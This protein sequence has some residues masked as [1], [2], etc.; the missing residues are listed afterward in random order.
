M[1]NN[2]DRVIRNVYFVAECNLM[3]L[4]FFAA[5]WFRGLGFSATKHDSILFFSALVSWMLATAWTRFRRVYFG[6]SKRLFACLKT[7]LLFSLF[8]TLLAFS[9]KEAGY[10][11]LIVGYFIALFAVFVAALHFTGDLYVYAL[12]R[13]HELLRNVMALGHP[14]SLA[15]LCEQFRSHPEHG[16]AEPVIHSLDILEDHEMLA[17]LIRQHSVNE[18]ILVVPFGS[19]VDFQ[20]VFDEMENFGV[21]VSIIPDMSLSVPVPLR[22]GKMFDYPVFLLQQF[23]LDDSVNKLWK[24]LFDVFFSAGVLLVLSPIFLIIALYVKV[25]SPGPVLFQQKRTGYNQKEFGVYKFRSMRFDKQMA[26][27]LQAT[28]SDPRITPVG[29]FMR[30]T[31]IDELPQFWNVLKGDMS[32]VGPR[33]HMLAHTEEFSSRVGGY[34]WRHHVRPGITGWAQVNGWRGLTDTEEK[35][36]KRVECDLWYVENW[37]LWLDIKIVFMTLFAQTARQNAV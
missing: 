24:R 27:T 35:I 11:R 9:F 26:N 21:R 13:S 37:T 10:S 4:A 1:Y 18:L 12:H 33:P 3:L 14:D 34:L 7:L 32:V 25:T 22:A 30:R 17:S 19:D 6:H 5:H 8:L 23:P 20:N 2:F 15:P 28:E 29:R 31:N 16:Y 36:S